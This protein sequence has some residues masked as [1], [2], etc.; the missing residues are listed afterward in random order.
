[1]EQAPERPSLPNIPDRSWRRIPATIVARN[2]EGRELI[3]GAAIQH[4][5]KITAGVPLEVTIHSF[6]SGCE[7]AGGVD[8]TI[9][10][11]NAD[12]RPW[13]YTHAPDP[14]SGVE[15]VCTSQLKVFTQTFGIVFQSKGTATM[16]AH[17][18]V[19]HGRKPD[20]P[21]KLTSTVVVE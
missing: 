20:A 18:I 14:D 15:Y 2:Y 5:P 17:G 16:R 7:E 6:G 13:D 3:P 1:M 9:D 4:A 19:S 21:I 12:L 11:L 10:V 8:G